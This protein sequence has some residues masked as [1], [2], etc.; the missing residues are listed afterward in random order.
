MQRQVA[1][2]G[3]DSGIEQHLTSAQ[4]AVIEDLCAKDNPSKSARRRKLP[5]PRIALATKGCIIYSSS[6][7]SD[8]GEDYDHSPPQPPAC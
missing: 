4:A 2:G 7:E 6:D 8:H 1:S 5:I 3:M